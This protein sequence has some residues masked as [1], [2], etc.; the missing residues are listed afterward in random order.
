MDDIIAG[1]RRLALLAR[2][3][4]IDNV[5]LS[6]LVVTVSLMILAGIYLDV[7]AIPAVISCHE[8]TITVQHQLASS[9]G[10]T[11]TK[12]EKSTPSCMT[13]RDFLTQF[14][15]SLS[16]YYPTPYL[17]NGHL[18]TI[19][20]ALVAQPRVQGRADLIKY[21]R[22]IIEMPDGGV[23]AL[24][25]YPSNDKHTVAPS[26]PILV[27]TH[28]LTGGSH[29]SYVEDVVHKMAHAPYHYRTVV[30]NF[31]G[32]ANSDVLT[33]QLYCAA[34]TADLKYV[35]EMIQMR[36]P[37]APLAACGFSLGA[38]VLTKYVGELGEECP[39]IT[40]V[41]VGNPLNLVIGSERLE[42]GWFSKRVYSYRMACSLIKVFSKHAYLFENH[43]NVDL[44][45]VMKSSSVRE[46]DASLTAKV[47]GYAD[48]DEY[49]KLG[50]SSLYVPSI[51]IPAM[52]LHSL[53]DP[54]VPKES[55]PT[56]EILNNPYCVLVTT[57]YGGH[58]GWFE[59]MFRTNRWVTKPIV[60]YLTAMIL[61]HGS[62][63]LSA[64]R[65][66]PSPSPFTKEGQRLPPAAEPLDDN[67]SKDNNTIN[68]VVKLTG[69]ANVETWINTSRHGNA[70]AVSEYSGRKSQ[71]VLHKPP[72]VLTTLLKQFGVLGVIFT[73][74]AWAR[75]RSSWL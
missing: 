1:L 22:E 18:Q 26:T 34:Y 21:E 7:M 25:W 28:G 3:I 10:T 61:A 71:A 60:Q 57:K 59:G 58:L 23:V 46:F 54:I 5:L 39:L 20:A 72:S 33:P 8:E 42:S 53:D 43:P 67:R 73:V 65:K 64:R 50:S 45:A 44:D 17:F 69:T 24:D 40:Y 12:D 6:V 38:N 75:R 11:D 52:F 27:L 4:S 63:P 9:S 41:S 56:E 15:P 49:Y 14:V 30:M 37:N 68:N 74:F 47:F 32:C 62:L 55:I 29:E 19:Y 66:I 31:R 51:R 70:V 13:L 36:Y 48:V 35:V 2:D 16:G